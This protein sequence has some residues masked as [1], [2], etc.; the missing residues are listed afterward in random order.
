MR[1]Y[2]GMKKEH[3]KGTRSRKR[4]ISDYKPDRF[5]DLAPTQLG[6]EIWGLLTEHD[7]LIRMETATELGRA[8]VEAVAS[9]LVQQYGDA[10]RDHRVKR[11]IG[12][13]VK[14]ILHDLGYGPLTANVRVRVGGLFKRGTRYERYPQ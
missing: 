5:S 2:W 7:N 10:V 3:Q 14:Q 9:R 1:T 4:A 6:Q 13:M 8:A 11:M 12:H